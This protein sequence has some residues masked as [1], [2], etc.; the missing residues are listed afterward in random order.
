[1][2]TFGRTKHSNNYKI[3]RENN[4]KHSNSARSKVEMKI[5]GGKGWMEGQL[6]TV[7]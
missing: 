2:E 1:M 7:Q 3:L 5:E 6:V 4:L